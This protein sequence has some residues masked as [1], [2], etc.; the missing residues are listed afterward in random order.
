MFVADLA[1][2]LSLKTQILTKLPQSLI[3]NWHDSV[4]MSGCL[5]CHMGGSGYLG[6]FHSDFTFNFSF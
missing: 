6:S 5:L 3:P 2:L 1:L 4:I